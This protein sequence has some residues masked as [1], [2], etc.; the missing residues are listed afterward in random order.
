M[1]GFE[2]EFVLLKPANLELFRTFPE[3]AR[4]ANVL[5]S[6]G[7]AWV[8]VDDA[9]YG[10]S[11]AM[12]T[13]TMA[14]GWLLPL[15]LVVVCARSWLGLLPCCVDRKACSW[16]IVQADANYALLLLR[17]ASAAAS[18]DGI[19]NSITSHVQLSACCVAV[20]VCL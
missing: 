9:I 2:L 1:V 8:P 15:L 19:H 18:S 7:Q 20:C 3:A 12:S 10:Q 6:A 4:G 5:L 16:L 17:I 14:G 13:S 11:S